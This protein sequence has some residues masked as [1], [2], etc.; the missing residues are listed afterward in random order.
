[1]GNI[2]K[3]S[4]AAAIGLHAMT[5]MAQKN[6]G[7]I[8]VKEIAETLDISYNHLSKVLQRL[9]KAELVQSI[10]GFGGGFKL[11]KDINSITFLEI[12]EAID[13]RFH[14]SKCLLNKNECAHKCIMGDF[15][16]SINK[17][18]E[19]FFSQ[20]KLSDFAK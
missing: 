3:I 13:G 7:L 15:I 4:D 16:N 14:P 5:V 6:D 11:A 1:M 19:D 2:L 17:Q 8:S 20:K 9:V 12:Y 10:K 18:V